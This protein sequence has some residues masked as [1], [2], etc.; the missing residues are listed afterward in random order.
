MIKAIV[1][2][3]AG[4]MGQRL[5]HVIQQSPDINLAG[6][7]E[8][9]GH[10]AVGKDAGQMA[11][12]DKLGLEIRPSLEDV[13]ADG[14]VIIDF[15]APEAT[16]ANIRLAAKRG[17]AMVIGTT[18]LADLSEIKEHGRTMRCVLAPNFSIG[19]NVMF[20]VTGLIAG[21][22][23]R[24]FDMEILEVHHRLKKDA[25]SG[26]ALQLGRILAQAVDRN[27][28]EVAVYERRGLIGQRSDEEIGLQ[29]LRAGDIVG[30][31]TVM[32]GGQGERLE[33]IHRAHSRDNF[34]QGALRAAKWLLNQ[35]PGLYDM[36]DVL[37]LKE[38]RTKEKG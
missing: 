23:G 8:R 10:P 4:R 13:I 25:P 17:L 26:T 2:G 1:A 32:F 38:Q 3:A 37:G 15:T 30:E 5:I 14:D 34:A 20:Y 22:V 29:T 9:P 27:L 35:G 12:L 19:V 21:I 36:Q 16:L 18:G 7:F 24:D 31:H 33:V 6:A 28:D 11:G